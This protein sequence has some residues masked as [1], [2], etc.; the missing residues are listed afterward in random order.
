MYLDVWMI[1]TIILSFGLC[2]VISR[3][4]GV[5]AG[6]VGIL[7]FLENEKII[8]ILEDGSVTRY[9]SWGEKPAKKKRKSNVK[10]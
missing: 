1:V 2:H 7:R 3:R 6:A 9:A 10:V 8:K 4:Q 5:T